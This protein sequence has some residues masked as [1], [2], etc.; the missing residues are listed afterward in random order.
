VTDQ[1]QLP[2]LQPEIDGSR[3]ETINVHEIL[4]MLDQETHGRADV[5][6]AL[7]EALP[8]GQGEHYEA[9]QKEFMYAAWMTGRTL[10]DDALASRP[11]SDRA[12]EV[13]D[14]ADLNGRP[15]FVPASDREMNGN[16]AVY[17]ADDNHAIFVNKKLFTNEL[18]DNPA[19]ET[20][21]VLKDPRDIKLARVV[22]VLAHEGAHQ[23]LGSIGNG[24]LRLPDDEYRTKAHAT[25]QLLLATK[26]KE[27]YGYTLDGVFG[28]KDGYNWQ[29]EVMTEEER[30]AEGYGLMAA[31]EVLGLLGYSADETEKLINTAVMARPVDDAEKRL[32][33]DR[34][35]DAAGF[36]A[37]G[38]LLDTPEAWAGRHQLVGYSLPLTPDEMVGRLN[39]LHGIVT[40][41]YQAARAA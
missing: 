36:V 4:A 20:D 24:K 23:T 40:E 6:L 2:E 26:G 31:R 27:G 9:A 15:T 16:M 17:D 33:L 14:D 30:F 11:D 29:K 39:T 1:E 32:R 7:R 25:G 13:I 19:R 34:A 38:Q 22:A 8:I 18:H 37:L 12:M 21:V 3:P 10:G 28:V 41:A 35:V 5:V